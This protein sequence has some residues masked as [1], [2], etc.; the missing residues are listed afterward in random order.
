MMLENAVSMAL[1][2]LKTAAAAAIT[3]TTTRG[4]NLPFLKD[5]KR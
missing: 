5:L 4:A 1:A 2:L 3:T